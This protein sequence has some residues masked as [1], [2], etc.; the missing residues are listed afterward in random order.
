MGDNTD[1]MLKFSWPDGEGSLIY[2]STN[3]LGTSLPLTV[4][5]SLIFINALR[6]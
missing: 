6:H 2:A 3:T 1:P 4:T 5:K